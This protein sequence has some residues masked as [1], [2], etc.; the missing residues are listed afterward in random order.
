MRRTILM[1]GAV[2]MTVCVTRA[3]ESSRQTAMA[4][5]LLANERALYEAVANNDKPAFRA[6][7]LPEGMWTTASGFIP[8]GQLADHLTS[9]QLPK[10]GGENLHVTWTDDNA[11]MVGYVRTGGGS[12]NRQSFAITTVATTLWTKHDGK[13]VAVHH[14]ET[15]LTQ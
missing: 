15:D 3:Q 4:S 8:M 9:F 7:V 1:L 5:T 11:A 2:L 6:L 12:F 13:W 10:W 14:Q